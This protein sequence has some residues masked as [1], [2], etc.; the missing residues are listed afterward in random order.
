M[1]AGLFVIILLVGAGLGYFPLVEPLNQNLLDAQYQLLKTHWPRPAGTD[2]VIVGIDEETPR[3]LREPFALWHPHLGKFLEAAAG[4]GASAVGLDVAL[5]ERSYDDIVPGYDKML[6]TGILNAR[7][8]TALVLAVTVDP[9]GRARPLFPAFAGAA[10]SDAMG[11]ALLP[12]DSDGK[13]RH[14]DERLGEQ[15]SAVPTLAGQIARRLGRT[16]GHGLINFALGPEYDYIPLQ[17]VLAWHDARDS[18]KLG[19]AFRGKVVLM[20]SVFKYEDRLPAPVHL[21][22][23]EDPRL[24]NTPSILLHAQ[25]LRSLVNGGL[26]AVAP[27]WTV[28]ALCMLM[29]ISWFLAGN[30]WLAAGVALGGGALVGAASTWLL[31]R[32]W[33]VPPAPIVLT[34]ML[35][36]AARVLYEFS[37]K[38]RERQRLRRVFSAY[39]SPQIMQKILR[40]KAA[41][42]LGGE[43]YFICVLFADMR[44][45]SVRIEGMKPEAVIDMLNRYFAEITAS[46]HGVGGTLDKFIGD[47]VM[48]FFGAP[49]PLENPCI[50]AFQA[51]R[52]MLRRVAA[53]NVALAAR[54]EPP[55]AIGIGLHAGDA[56]VGNVGAET[57]HGYT[58][59][60]DTVNVASR[61]EG[62]TKEVNFP[63][64][65]SATVVNMLDGQS[66]FVKLGDKTIK[67]H[68]PVEVY[69]WR[70]DETVVQA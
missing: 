30:A 12:L 58:A 24:I 6:L 32:G 69:G 7:R 50:P 26:I 67:G 65:C 56:V 9:A 47:G 42:G 52:D 14:F 28:L 16:V 49:Q 11:Y 41:P 39:V 59:I 25:A 70:P 63:L 66:G 35:A 57:R 29:A 4:A 54:G 53:M 21:A 19:N 62:L 55:I 34:L 3:V 27:V 22:A 36:L 2:V 45:F 64:V 44:R 40:D 23:W 61:I 46:I 10:G 33:Y 20:G 31:T 37:L 8:N 1:R 38:L 18:D 17:T 68:T 60:G 13:V 5:P 15:G 48:A 43:R 51:A